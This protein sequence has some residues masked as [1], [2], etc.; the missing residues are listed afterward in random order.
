[1]SKKQKKAS[2]LVPAAGAPDTTQLLADVRALIDT[3][4][5]QLA[6]AVN[7]ALV[8]L[9]WSIGERVHREIIGLSRAA[10][11]EQIVGTLAR[12]LTAG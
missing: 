3:G 11:G 12:Q 1:M 8:L 4:R 5:T 7:A 2:G 9:Y 6:Q 10:Y